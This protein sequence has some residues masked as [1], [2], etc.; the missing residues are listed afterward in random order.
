MTQTPSHPQQHGPA[1]GV[2]VEVGGQREELGGEGLGG[3]GDLGRPRISVRAPIRNRRVPSMVLRATLP[4][5]PSVTITS[6][7]SSK[8]SRPS[9]LP[10]KSNDGAA[11]PVG[12]QAVG[13]LL[14]R[15]ALGL[16]LA[17]GE[18]GHLGPVHPVALGREGRA[19]LGELH[20][21]GRRALG[22]GPRV[23]QDGGPGPLQVG[24]GGGDGRP[25]HA[26]QTP[27]PEQGRRHGGPGVP[28]RDHG[29]GLPVA[30]GLGRPHQGGVLLPPHPLPGVVVH[31]DDLAGREAREV[32]GVAHLPRSAHQGH[33]DAG[34]LGH[35]SGPGDDL[36]RGPVAAHGVDRHRECGQRVTRRP[37]D[38]SR[39]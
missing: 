31:A 2:G 24:D 5:N 3:L 34:L 7:V 18:Q 6:A 1:G 39:H 29:H 19:H 28:R 33:L 27:H 23:Q 14:Q 22:V 25:D 16:L 36:V 15:R 35:L 26:G 4:V 9:T 21:H 38:A 32:A 10:T 11:G 8:K 17:D 12:Q 30:D 13:L 20:Q 37:C